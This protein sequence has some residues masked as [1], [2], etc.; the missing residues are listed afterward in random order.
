MVNKKGQ[1]GLNYTKSAYIYLLP[2]IILMALFILYPL[3][4]T[5]I[6]SFKY[7]YRFLTGEFVSFSVRHYAD[8]FKDKVFLRAMINTAVIGFVFVPCSMILSLA[9]AMGLN[10]VKK[11]QGL[12][13]TLYYLPQV[14]NVIAAGFVFAL[15]FNNHYGLFNTV[16]GWFGVD[17]VAWISG[18]GIA[19]DPAL[20]TQSYFRCMFVLFCY[21]M[22]SGL[23]LKVLLFLGGLRSINPQ[24]Y[25]VA[26]IDGISKW[27]VF[28]K[29][30]LPLLSP[31]TLYIYITSTITAFK[32][33]SA[34][35]ALFGDKFGPAGDNSK[36]MITMVGYI[37]DKLGNYIKPG[38]VSMASAGAVI[39]FVMIMI[40]TGIQMKVTDRSV[41]Y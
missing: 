39:L 19:K 26:D 9:A 16:L 1:R 29:I 3:V 34:V 18:K 30:T 24:Y 20:Y 25:Q 2:A 13:T 37:M 23:S 32:A 6:T 27:K 33:Y 17:P 22:W 8:I 15:I 10:R 41:H 35:I 12:L 5:I 40:L 21:Q 38:A 31:T 14:T 11:L 36:M 28:T 7:N 4:N